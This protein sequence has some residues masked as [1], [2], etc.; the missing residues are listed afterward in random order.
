M[1]PRVLVGLLRML[2]QLPLAAYRRLLGHSDVS[3]HHHE[4][5]V[6]L[7]TKAGSTQNLVDFCR[8]VTPACRLNP[9]LFNGHLQTFWTAVKGVEIEVYYKRKIFHSDDPTYIGTF[10]VDFTTQPYQS[11]EPDL[12]PRTSYYDD[13]EWE[14]LN[15]GLNDDIPM[16]VVLHGLAGGSNEL[17]LRS[18][19]KPIVDA[20]WKT[21]VVNSRGC[22][23]SKIESEVLYNARATW[24][25]RQ[26]I[27]WLREKYPNRPLFGLGF[28]LG[29]NILIN[30]CY[31]FFGGRLMQLI[32]EVLAD[33]R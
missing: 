22:A 21:C 27:K 8:S 12:P 33:E 24:D 31:P 10:A 7:I 28:S 20:G 25:L 1:I 18:V 23:M 4:H 2:Y 15:H 3:F 6:R 5:V 16:L 30:V 11:N 9:F 13:D 19:L 17:Y 14:R 29:A 26:V 32:R